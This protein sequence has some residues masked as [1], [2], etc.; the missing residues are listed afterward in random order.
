MAAK[1]KVARYWLEKSTITW[2]T[3]SVVTW[4][5]Q[6]VHGRSKELKVH[7]KQDRN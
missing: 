4:L 3:E 5:K 6:D 2:R 7:Q 1:V